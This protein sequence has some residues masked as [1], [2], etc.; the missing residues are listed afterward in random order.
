MKTI[1]L[2]VHRPLTMTLEEC[3]QKRRTCREVEQKDISLEDLSALLWS[4]AGITSPEDGR[5]TTPST[6]DLKGVFVC[7]A[8]QDGCWR[9]DE[10]KNELVQLTD[11]DVRELTTSYQFEYVKQAP[12]TLIFVA[13]H[14]RTKKARPTGVF[15]DAGTMGQSCYLAAASLGLKGC[16]RASFDHDKLAQGMKLQSFEEPIMLFTVGCAK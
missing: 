7:V 10:V 13:D 6:L 1:Q 11:E 2:P 9:F 3:L 8:R 16:I 15:C 14:E 5:R 12:V 4:C